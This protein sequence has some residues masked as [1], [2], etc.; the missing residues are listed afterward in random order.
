MD[1][2]S[3]LKDIVIMGATNRPDLIDPAFLRP[4]RFEKLLLVPMPDEKTRE[5]IFEVHISKMNVDKRVAAKELAALTEDF[6]GAE[7]EAVCREAGLSKIRTIIED[8]EKDNKLDNKRP[9]VT[10]DAFIKAIDKFK[11]KKERPKKEE[12]DY[13]IR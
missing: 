10:R 3:N 6:S 12:K 2:V 4:G 8:I 11:S 7:I 5:K 13:A 9:V 1:G